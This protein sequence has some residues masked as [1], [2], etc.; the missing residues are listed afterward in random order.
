MLSVQRGVEAIAV[1]QVPEAIAWLDECQM[2]AAIIELLIQSPRSPLRKRSGTATKPAPTKPANWVRAPDWSTTAARQPLAETANP[3]KNPA[4]IFEVPM[5]TIFWSGSTSSPR[6][7]AKFVAVTI[8]SVSDTSMMPTA[9]TR[10]G[11]TSDHFVHGSAGTGTP[12]GQS[13]DSLPPA[14][15]VPLDL[16][17]RRRRGDV[18]RGSRTDRG[19]CARRDRHARQAAYKTGRRLRRSLRDDL[20][21]EDSTS[22]A[23]SNNR[24]HRTD[25]SRLVPG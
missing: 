17:W 4:A 11:P 12:L 9:P 18:R 19:A 21:P 23:R 2:H 24:A 22:H 20:T 5:P 15:P 10:S 14:R 13:T 1:H 8:V 3:W 7:E 25:F 6:R 16:R